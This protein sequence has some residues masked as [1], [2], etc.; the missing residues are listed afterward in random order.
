M[1]PFVR[2]LALAGWCAASAAT[3]AQAPAPASETSAFAAL[4][5]SRSAVVVDVIAL[6]SERESGSGG[7]A[8]DYPELLPDNEFSDRFAMPL[9]VG[10]APGQIRDLGSGV[11]LSSDGLILTSGHIVAGAEET[12]VRLRDGRKFS[13]R[14]VGAD[15]R[16][17][18]GLLKIEASGLPVALFGDSAALAPGT[19]V[20]AI[21][22]P[23]GFQ[24]SVTTGVVSATDRYLSGAGEIPFIQT[25]VAIN[26]GSSGSPLFNSRGEVVALNSMIY[27]GSGG[28]MGLSFAVPINLTMRIAQQL[29]THGSVR[30]AHLGAQMQEVSPALAQAFGLLDASGALVVHVDAAGPAESAGLLRGD[31]VRA[32][33]GIPVTHFAR[34]LQTVAQRE[35]G[36]RV[37][38]DVWRHGRPTALWAILSKDGSGETRPRSDPPAD[39]HDGLGLSLGDLSRAQ[40]DQLHVSDAVMVRLAAGAARSEGI[41]AGDLILAINDVS[42]RSVS[43]FTRIVSR[44]PAGGTV[45]LLVQR[46]GRAVY[47][48][49]ALPH[50]AAR[51][52]AG[53]PPGSPAN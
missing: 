45:A 19:W 16:T 11:I 17:D 15:R 43:E 10:M 38:L 51:R 49:I 52:P 25:D 53:A 42:V 50:K 35:P 23:F 28:Y 27:S 40:R 32:V 41:R 2:A 12:Q 39:W 44:M 33:D 46:S 20:A 48:P 3:L 24:G 18:V 6:R 34:L 31:V 26:P 8:D 1:K 47:V 4:V 13:A 7:D 5:A 29:R 9:P 30:R 14:L 37:R 36:A 22:S 21:G